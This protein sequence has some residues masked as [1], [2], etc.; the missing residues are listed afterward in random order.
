MLRIRGRSKRHIFSF[1]FFCFCQSCLLDGYFNSQR[2][3]ICS[4]LLKT[5]ALLVM[6][7]RAIMCM[8]T[9]W[10]DLAALCKRGGGGKQTVADFSKWHHLSFIIQYKSM[11][12]PSE[13]TQSYI[14]VTPVQS[15]RQSFYHIRKTSPWMRL[16]TH[17]DRFFFFLKCSQLLMLSQILDVW[18]A[19][20]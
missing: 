2:K 10:M 19:S 11:L 12:F 4:S 3:S 14:I 15:H 9:N 1:Y 13:G 8:Q 6:H 5:H 18:K 16:C 7:A 20:F 17:P